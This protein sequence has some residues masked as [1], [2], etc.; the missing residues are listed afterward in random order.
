MIAVDKVQHLKRFSHLCIS[1]H[2]HRLRTIYIKL[3]FTKPDSNFNLKADKCTYLPA[4]KFIL[5]VVYP[6]NQHLIGIPES[7]DVCTQGRN[8]CSNAKKEREFMLMLL[9]KLKFV[10]FEKSPILPSNFP[11]L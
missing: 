6:L 3:T 9:N 7:H 10:Y 5:L 2:M 1:R 8:G 4:N 11:I